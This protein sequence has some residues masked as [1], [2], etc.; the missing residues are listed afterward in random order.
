MVKFAGAVGA[1]AGLA[2]GLAASVAQ[3]QV[4]NQPSAPSLTQIPGLTDAQQPMASAIAN[5]CPTIATP[6]NQPFLSAD[7]LDLANVCT[8]MV[9]NGN[10]VTG[11]AGT[12]NSYGLNAGQLASALQQ[13]NGEELVAP[14]E[15]LNTAQSGQNSAISARLSALR[16]GGGAASTR[17]G[18]APKPQRTRYAN[19]GGF[20]PSASAGA[21]E[22]AMESRLSGFLTGSG[23]WGDKD[24]DTTS[25]GFDFNSGS[26]TAGA[27]YRLN[28]N[29]IIGAALG[30]G[31]FDADFDA[32]AN[33]A[34]G[35][36]IESDSGLLSLYGTYYVG[37]R[38]YFDAILT[39]TRANY[40]STRRVVI[41]SQTA[42]PSEN[43]TASADF[44]ATQTSLS[45]GGGYQ[46]PMGAT[47]LTPY[48]RAA[49]QRTDVDGFTESGAAGLNLAYDSHDVTSLT[50][51]LGAQV[52]HSIST[53]F[54]V[55]APFFT[56]EW[57]HEFKNDDSGIGAQY[58]ADPTNL[59]RFTVRFDSPDRNYFNVG[60]GVGMTLAQGWSAFASY[61]TLLGLDDVSS[62]TVTVGARLE[63]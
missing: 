16:L 5:V 25:E 60:A 62:H 54:G 10:A 13:I 29:L 24:G 3:A 39:G 6:S 22:P 18:L 42:Q 63:F 34:S 58:A 11:A 41:V 40:D 38:L 23:N 14:R 51:A 21:S 33:S 28:D 30:Y 7:T 4:V 48:A 32:T 12:A 53:D 27:D 1:T 45:I 61:D 50:S 55:V 49:Y 56:A 43:R 8:R 31:S 35:Q 2:F 20:M 44:D 17:F 47:L 19:A 52:S 9:Q 36:G 57:I 15:Q 59:S 37:E 26:I 46:Y